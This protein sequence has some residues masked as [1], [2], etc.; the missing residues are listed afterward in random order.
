MLFCSRDSYRQRV[1]SG[2]RFRGSS[3]SVRSRKGK[4]GRFVW[5]LGVLLVLILAFGAFTFFDKKR[6]REGEW[7][8]VQTDSG[9]VSFAVPPAWIPPDRTGIEFALQGPRGQTVSLN[10]IPLSIAISHLSVREIAEQAQR[11]M[12]RKMK[13]EMGDI[14]PGEYL[15]KE[16]VGFSYSTKAE[17]QSLRGQVGVVAANA[18]FYVISFAGRAAAWEHDGRIFSRIRRE[19]K[20]K[21]TDPSSVR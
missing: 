7:K 4:R 19:S 6:E 1:D 8:T 5:A 9:R 11:Q 13:A 20:I 18:R 10:V 21:E 15:G 14:E 17:G 16:G 3:A 12:S 2:V